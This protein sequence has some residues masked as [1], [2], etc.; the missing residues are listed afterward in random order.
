VLSALGRPLE[1]ADACEAALAALIRAEPVPPGAVDLERRIDLGE[2]WA[3]LLERLDD[4]R[5]GMLRQEL[6]ALRARLAA[7]RGRHLRPV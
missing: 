6:V 2:A 1:A 5:A 7:L 4:P 3:D